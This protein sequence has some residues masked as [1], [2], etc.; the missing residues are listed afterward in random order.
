MLFVRPVSGGVIDIDLGAKIKLAEPAKTDV[1]LVTR[2]F[3]LEVPWRSRKAP[4]APLTFRSGATDRRWRKVGA[5]AATVRRAAA[6]TREPPSLKLV[7]R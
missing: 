4:P 5:S 3:K 6:C 7:C 2:R 1:D